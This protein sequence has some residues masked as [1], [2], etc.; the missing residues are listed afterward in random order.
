MSTLSSD[1]KHL[2]V[3]YQAIK[4]MIYRELQS[5]FGV[6]KYG[7]AITIFE[8]ILHISFYLILFAI[9]KTI[10]ISNINSVYFLAIAIINNS[11]FM[12]VFL[13]S[14]NIIISNKPLF[15]FAQIKPFT[16][17]IAKSIL[18]FY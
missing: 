11:I 10:N 6:S 2:S 8:P 18:E 17:I 16:M 14:T 7:W 13:S 12:N 9:I 5:K 3:F 4:A 1:L 15:A